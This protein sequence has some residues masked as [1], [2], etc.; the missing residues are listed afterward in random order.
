MAVHAFAANVVELT[1]VDDHGIRYEPAFLR[2]GVPG[3]AFPDGSALRETPATVGAQCSRCDGLHARSVSNEAGSGL[4]LMAT[5]SPSKSTPS[6]GGVD[7]AHVEDWWR[8]RRRA[9]GGFTGGVVGE[10]L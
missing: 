1:G 3:C 5:R 10:N 9:L 8:P 7:N 6:P 4:G 2:T